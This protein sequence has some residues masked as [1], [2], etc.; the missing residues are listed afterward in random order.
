MPIS[1]IS[2]SPLPAQLE[3]VAQEHHHVVALIFFKIAVYPH[4]AQVMQARPALLPGLTAHGL[5]KGLAAL[6]PAPGHIPGVLVDMAHQ[7]G[8]PAAQQHHAHPHVT[9]R[10]RNQITRSTR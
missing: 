8:L 2:A 7:Q 9:G 10:V 4:Q 3:I 1:S 5:F 6:H